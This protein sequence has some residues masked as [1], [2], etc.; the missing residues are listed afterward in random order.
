MA[1]RVNAVKVCLCVSPGC[2]RGEGQSIPADFQGQLNRHIW[3]SLRG[4]SEETRSVYETD[5]FWETIQTG[6]KKDQVRVIRWL[7]LTSNA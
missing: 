6:Q 1:K 3:T 4:L 2:V 7:L 5:T